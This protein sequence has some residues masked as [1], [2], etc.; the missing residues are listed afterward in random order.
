MNV[1]KQN[2]WLVSHFLIEE[3]FFQSLKSLKSKSLFF[4]SF[5]IGS[6]FYSPFLFSDL[7][8]EG[9]SECPSLPEIVSAMVYQSVQAPQIE[10]RDQQVFKGD[11]SNPSFD[12]YDLVANK[13][14]V[15][16]LSLKPP[17]NIKEDEEYT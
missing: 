14:S 4:M 1:F 17:E 16:L 9:M 13:P 10:P 15:V 12:S 5:F 2:S 6:L 7:N 3:V 11:P 8:K